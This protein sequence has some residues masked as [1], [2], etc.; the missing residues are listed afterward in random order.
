M[1]GAGG[2][3][4]RGE[5]LAH[6]VYRVHVPWAADVQVCAVTFR[7]NSRHEVRPQT[8]QPAVAF[9]IFDRPAAGAKIDHWANADVV[10]W[11]PRGMRTD[12][13]ESE[14]KNRNNG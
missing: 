2:A 4:W 5:K 7:D 11:P 3:C 6:V 1:H 10:S 8:N 13:S 12:W 14:R 9:L